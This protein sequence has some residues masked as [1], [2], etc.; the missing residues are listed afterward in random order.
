LYPI[1]NKSDVFQVFVQFKSIVENQFS[2]SIKQFQC[3]GGGEYMSKQFK[4]FLVTHGILHRVSCPHTPQQNGVAERK[5]RHIM[6]MGLSLL[7]QSHLSS[8]FWVDAFVTSV[9]IINRLPSSVLGDVSPFFK[10]FK[11]GPDYSLFRSFGCS[12]FP[13]LRP[14]STHKL[15]FRSKHC[16]FLGYSSNQRGY[17][18][19]DPV[20]RKVYVSRHVVFDESRFPATE[21]GLSD[22]A[23]IAS[24]STASFPSFPSF[25]SPSSMQIT[26][27]PSAVPPAVQDPHS[28]L[29]N[30]PL[31]S[32][33]VDPS[34]SI[35]SSDPLISSLSEA[36]SALIPSHSMVTRSKTGTLRSQSFPDYT[37]FFSTKHPVCALTSVSIPIEPTCY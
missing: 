5:H 11:K 15:M 23:P 8:I 22:S 27:V 17:R 25:H 21:G 6:E 13:L 3:D 4:K 2:S 35:E 28:P 33:Q 32:P 24:V 29:P 10:L 7:A 19:L 9:F 37:S 1:H 20:S 14:Y 18:C 26:L 30:A 34:P 31:S 12:C 16:I 36:S